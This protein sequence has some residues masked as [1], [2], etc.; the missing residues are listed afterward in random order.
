MKT[1]IEMIAE[2][3]ESQIVKHGRTIEMDAEINKGKQLSDA[4]SVLI[5]PAIGT[6][7]KR[8][9]LMPSDW[10]DSVALH[11]CKK[12]YKERL[13]I[14]GALIAAELDRIMFE[15][16]LIEELNKEK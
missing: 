11:M 16:T 14:S 15:E 4:A 13:I 9:S 12:T 1:G 8:L 10:D 6:P 3:R 2:E 5:T 7:R